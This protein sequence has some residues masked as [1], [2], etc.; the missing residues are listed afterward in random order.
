M[1]LGVAGD[2]GS[3]A[4]PIPVA[5]SSR[6]APPF[7]VPATPRGIPYG[8]RKGT[9]QERCPSGYGRCDMTRNRTYALT[10]VSAAL[11][12]V[13][14]WIF[15]D[16]MFKLSENVF[17]KTNAKDGIKVIADGTIWTYIFL[18]LIIAAG[19]YQARR[20]PAEGIETK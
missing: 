16:G 14:C 7:Y 9:T 6:L 4:T 15:A 2:D 20:I 12:I 10:M 17:S 8:Q 19:I 1:R 11:Y 3:P 18:G 13:L 5:I